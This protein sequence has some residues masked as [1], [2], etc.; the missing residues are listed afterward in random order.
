MADPNRLVIFNPDDR[1]GLCGIVVLQRFPGSK[2]PRPAEIIGLEALP[3]EN[4]YAQISKW[5]FDFEVRAELDGVRPQPVHVVNL[6]PPLHGEPLYRSLVRPPLN[7]PWFSA[8]D[9]VTGY[10]C[11]DTDRALPN[12]RAVSWLPRE[13]ADVA[14][15][16]ALFE[17]SFKVRKDIPLSDE[18]AQALKRL[19]T[20]PREP[21]DRDRADVLATAAG[22][23]AYL[24]HRYNN[25]SPGRMVQLNYY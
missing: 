3:V 14:L 22:M 15:A 23:A 19:S 10:R 1:L 12:V 2:P 6:A 25:I 21:E 8:R 4:R 13:A 18:L 24:H 16:R 20:K 5:F 9:R 17:G 11:S 7:Q